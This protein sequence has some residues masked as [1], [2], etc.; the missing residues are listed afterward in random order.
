MP[1][2][3]LVVLVPSALVASAISGAIGMGGGVVLLAIMASV[4]DPMLVVPVH[5]AVQLVSNST[6]TLQLWRNIDWR[7]AA[8][9]TPTMILGAFLG[10][11]LYR[12]AG[13]PWFK[14][15]IGAFVLAFLAWKRFKLQKTA[16]YSAMP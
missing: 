16:I 2:A 4:L 7:I 6:R 13:M 3:L 10:L 12:G 5:G 9:Y 8:L 14:P 11:Q 15:A 1:L